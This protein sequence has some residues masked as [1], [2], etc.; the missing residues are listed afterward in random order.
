MHTWQLF[1]EGEQPLYFP[2]GQ[3]Q[4]GLAPPQRGDEMLGS[5]Q[6]TTCKGYS[7]PCRVLLTILTILTRHTAA[8]LPVCRPCQIHQQS[9][10]P[11]QV[12]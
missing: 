1:P 8:R 5:S 12:C 6:L 11:L 4:L 7:R 3:K 10:P 9:G 2:E